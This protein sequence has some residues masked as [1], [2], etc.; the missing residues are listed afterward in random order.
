MVHT[1]EVGT[2]AWQPDPTEGWVASEV[3]EK[4]VDGEKVKLVFTLENGE[5]SRGTELCLRKKSSYVEII[6]LI[7]LCLY[8]RKLPRR[9]C[10]SWIRTQMKSCRL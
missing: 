3:T 1:Y 10:R 2:R 8:R 7:M 6:G 9:L 5:V 4:V